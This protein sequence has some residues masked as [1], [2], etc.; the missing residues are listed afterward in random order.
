MCPELD[1][2]HRLLGSF[3]WSYELVLYF[4]IWIVCCVNSIQTL[5]IKNTFFLLFETVPHTSPACSKWR[6][7]ASGND[8][9]LCKVQN[10]AVG[11]TPR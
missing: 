8:K 5:G 3:Y 2:Q 11:A 6:T 1:L 10:K 9:Y 7:V 4:S